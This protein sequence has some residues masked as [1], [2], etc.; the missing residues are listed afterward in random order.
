MT[1]TELLIEA[2]ECSA[3]DWW[4]ELYDIEEAMKV[5]AGA[6]KERPDEHEVAIVLSILEPEDNE[7]EGINPLSSYKKCLKDMRKKLKEIKN[8][9][10]D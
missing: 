9:I 8:G 2:M 4:T 1:N 7:F 5:I 6:L 10:K 3:D